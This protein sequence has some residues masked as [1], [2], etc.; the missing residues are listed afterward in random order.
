[1]KIAI[2][3]TKP[4]KA[5]IE[6]NVAT[7]KELIRLAVNN[8]AEM[9]FFPELSITGYEPELADSLATTANDPRFAIFQQIS[10][11]QHITIALGAPV[12]TEQG[13]CI[14]LFIFQPGQ[15]PETYCKKY[16]HSSEEPFFVSGELFSGLLGNNTIAPAICY[17]LSVPQHASD[18]ANKGASVYI[19]SVVEDIEG[20]ERAIQKLSNTAA[21]H[22]MH[23]LMANVCGPTGAY[24]GGGKSSAWNNKGELAGQLDTSHEGILVYDTAAC[25]TSIKMLREEPV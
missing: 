19:A 15:S 16:L 12:R 10:V 24:Y 4:F 25:K 21:T 13:V 8:G 2:A 7:H 3:Q 17:E 11:S 14:S 20:V 23:V 6:K 22:T 1:M 18:A 9:I 5:D